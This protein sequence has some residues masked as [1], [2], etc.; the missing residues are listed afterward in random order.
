MSRE[1]DVCDFS[2]ESLPSWE[3][4]TPLRVLTGEGEGTGRQGRKSREWGLYT[5]LYEF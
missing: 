1:E 5:L 4:K 3:E 2:W